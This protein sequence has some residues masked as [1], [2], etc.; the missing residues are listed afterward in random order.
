[1]PVIEV[2]TVP[3]APK[4]DRV[5]GFAVSRLTGVDEIVLPL[6]AK[7]LTTGEIAAGGAD[8]GTAP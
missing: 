7:G 3:P 2:G 5:A 6:S 4:C 8:P 1:M